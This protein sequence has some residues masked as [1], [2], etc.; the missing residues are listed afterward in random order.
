MKVSV[1][2]KFAFVAASLLATVFGQNP[3]PQIVGPVKPMA[4]APGSGAFVLSVYGANFVPGAIVNW[5]GQPRKTNFISGHELQA[6]ILAADVAKNTAGLISVTNPAPGGGDSSAGWAQVEVHDPVKAFAFKKNHPYQF[7]GYLLLAADFNHDGILD[8]MGQYGAFADFNA[9]RGDGTFHFDSIAGHFY[10]SLGAAY[11][12]FNGDGNLDL[13]Y[14]QDLLTNAN[15]WGAVSLGDGQ[16]KFTPGSRLGVIS[17]TH[18]GPALIHAGDF[19][20]D[21]KLDIVVADLQG[22]SIFLG[23]GEGS[24]HHF[25]DM[26]DSVY[27]V[28]GMLVGDFNGDGKLDVVI[29]ANPTA[30]SS[31]TY[32]YMFLGNGDGTFQSQRTILSTTSMSGGFLQLSDFNRDGILDLAFSTDS[33]ICVLLGN[34]DGSFQPRHCHTVGMQ[35]QFRYTIGDFDSDGLPD[36]VVS[37]FS[38]IADYKLTILPGNGDGTFQKGQTFSEPI[39]SELELVPGDFDHDGLLDVM[40]ATGSGMNAYL[41]SPN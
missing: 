2:I 3:V 41:Q 33:Q 10:D 40:L 28:R 35:F 9:G 15:V 13:V 22:F 26:S 11:G 34:G 39:F 12:D 23:N 6:H 31:G 1:L 16:G 24:F 32:L 38:D 14:A 19:N 7:G 37:Q 17:G 5:N 20:G 8:L 36:L 29:L 27:A 30:S 25:T 18:I 4:V 21:G